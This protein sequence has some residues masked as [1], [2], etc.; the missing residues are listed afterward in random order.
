MIQENNK[1]ET[2]D[3]KDLIIKCLSTIPDTI[4]VGEVPEYKRSSAPKSFGV[5]HKN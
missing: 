4:V 1:H 3:L 2:E 5:A